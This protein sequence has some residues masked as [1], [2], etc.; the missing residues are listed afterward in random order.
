MK[1]N[2]NKRKTTDGVEILWREFVACDSKMESYVDA[3]VERILKS[4]A[5]LVKQEKAQPNAST[6]TA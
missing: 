5:K 1:K 3:E 6:K 2:S 4:Q